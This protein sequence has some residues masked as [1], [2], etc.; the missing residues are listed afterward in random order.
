MYFSAKQIS[1]VKCAFIIS[2]IKIQHK[3][4]LLLHEICF[5]REL[6]TCHQ[7]LDPVNNFDDSFLINSTIAVTMDISSKYYCGVITCIRFGLY[8]T[9]DVF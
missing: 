3:N 9:D 1:Y 5:P 2:T 6:L 8:R 4:C 7:V